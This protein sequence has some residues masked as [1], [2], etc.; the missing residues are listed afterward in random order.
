LAVTIR[1]R[2]KGIRVPARDHIR[3]PKSQG[4]AGR[5]RRISA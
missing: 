5:T 1:R 2:G 3:Q 4:R